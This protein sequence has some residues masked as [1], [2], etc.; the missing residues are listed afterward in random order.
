MGVGKHLAVVAAVTGAPVGAVQDVLDGKVRR[1][2]SSASLDVDAV[3]AKTDALPKINSIGLEN[4][5]A[6][7]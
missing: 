4:N 6:A 3:Y 5:Q 1:W 2:P 7:Q